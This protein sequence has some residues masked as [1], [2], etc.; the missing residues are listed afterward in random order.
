MKEIKEE[1]KTFKVKAMCDCGGEYKPTG[2]VFDVWPPHYVHECNKCSTSSSFTSHYPK[3][4]HE[5][6]NINTTDK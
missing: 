2:R 6:I 4:V 3:L 5:N 1:V